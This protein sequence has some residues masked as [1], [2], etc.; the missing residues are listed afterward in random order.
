MLLDVGTKLGHDPDVEEAIYDD[1]YFAEP[2]TITQAHIDAL[3]E[4]GFD[5]DG[6]I[7]NLPK[8]GQSLV[9]LV[10]KRFSVTR[11]WLTGN[12]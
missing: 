5:V 1:F 9:E 3:L 4:R 6:R 12:H 8:H 10:R 2:V 7:L 11:N